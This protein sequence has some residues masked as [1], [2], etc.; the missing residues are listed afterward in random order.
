MALLS[1]YKFVIRQS[2]SVFTLHRK[3]K[4]SC[5]D[6]LDEVLV[7]TFLKLDHAISKFFQQSNICKR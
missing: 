5:G 3:V 1:N 6:V 4:N 2:G 7:G